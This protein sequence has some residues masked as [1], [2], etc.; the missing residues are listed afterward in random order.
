MNLREARNLPLVVINQD[1][2]N[3]VD[4]VIE[5]VPP[6]E[7]EMKDGYEPIPDPT[8][9]KAIPNRFHL[10]PKASAAADILIEIPN[11]PTLV[12]KH[13]ECIVWVHTDQRNRAL[14]EGG[15]VL[16]AGLRSRFRLSIGTMGPEALQREK[17]LEKLATINTNFS[18][19]PETY[20]SRRSQLVNGSTSRRRRK[21]R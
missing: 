4:I 2:E 15:V 5:S 11:D 6:S 16:Q 14:M 8:W 17:A 13:Y 21:V 20:T 9:I 18:V 3:D 19:R 7:K 1:A 10:G 12:G